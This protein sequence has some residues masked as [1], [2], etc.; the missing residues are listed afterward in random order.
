[1]SGDWRTCTAGLARRLGEP[2]YP[3][4]TVTSNAVDYPPTQKFSFPTAA[5][6]PRKGCYV[7]KERREIIT[8]SLRRARHH[9]RCSSLLIVSSNSC[10]R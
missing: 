7:P 1:M 9:A 8:E 10:E 6:P 4:V 3:S 5:Y 2:P